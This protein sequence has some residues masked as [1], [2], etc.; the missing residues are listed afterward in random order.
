MEKERLINDLH[1]GRKQ[2]RI[3]TEVLGHSLVRS[4]VHSHRSL[5]CLLC[6]ACF[7]CRLRCAHSFACSL[8]PSLARSLR[9]L[10][11]LDGFF[12]F[13]F[14]QF[15]PQCLPPP[16]LA[17]HPFSFGFST[18]RTSSARK[19]YFPFHRDPFFLFFFL[20]FFHS[21]FLHF[22]CSVCLSLPVYLS[23]FLAF[24]VSLYVFLFSFSVLFLSFFL[25]FFFS[26]FLSLSLSFF[27]FSPRWLPWR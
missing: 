3:Q 16:T 4:L 26:F 21:L 19:T 22:F 17:C 25:S 15:G 8:T 23:V 6:T 13:I 7:A 12:I 1:Y 10:C 9:S 18:S 20:F 27:L 14:F 11:Y 5:V 2:P 24:T